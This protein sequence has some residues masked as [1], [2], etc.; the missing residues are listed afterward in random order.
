MVGARKRDEFPV[1]HVTTLTTIGH[2]TCE[3]HRE[4]FEGTMSVLRCR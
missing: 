4:E 2:A 3:G 1:G